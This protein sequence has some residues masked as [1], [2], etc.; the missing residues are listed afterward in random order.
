MDFI[1]ALYTFGSIVLLDIVL[2]GDNAIII[3][4]KAA[5]LPS[6][7]R[8]KA[9]R[10][11]MIMAVVMRIV[12]SLFATWLITIPGLRFV[13]GLAL[14]YVAYGMIKDQ[15]DNGESDGSSVTAAGNF[16]SALIAIA[17]ADLSMSIDNI[18]AVAGAASGHFVALIFGLLLSIVIMMFAAELV[19][20]LIERWKW[21]AWVGVAL[22]VYIGG[23]LIYQDAPNVIALFQ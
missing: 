8:T 7:Q 1:L 17:I 9:I 20:K 2:S 23:H 14:F 12:L 18:L 4:A 15:M 22:V 3:G 10:Y 13:G 6:E 21:L 11:G 16:R 19:A 5:S